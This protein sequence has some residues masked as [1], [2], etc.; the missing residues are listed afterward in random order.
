MR[1]T[2]IMADEALLAQLAEIA[3]AEGLPL[4]EIIRQALRQ[5]AD[6]PQPPLRSVGIARSSGGEPIDWNAPLAGGPRPRG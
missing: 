2:T 6:Q 4:A 5:R 1:R 3:R